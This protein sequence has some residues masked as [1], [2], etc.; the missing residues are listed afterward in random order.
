V[1]THTGGCR[2]RAIRFETARDPEWVSYCHCADCR[3]AT[4][5]PVSCFVGFATESVK[6]G[7]EQPSAWL[8]GP[9]TRSFCGTCGSPVHYFDKRIPARIYF[10]IGAMDAPENYR[11]TLH[12]FISEKLP[13][14]HM[15]DGLP[16]YE[17][18]S[19]ERPRAAGSTDDTEARP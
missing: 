9:V 12:S 14:L 6:F 15:P 8:N 13:F 4:G 10:L 3:K 16:E 11:A 7:G 2:C 19:V 17:K 18:T 5:A 1:T